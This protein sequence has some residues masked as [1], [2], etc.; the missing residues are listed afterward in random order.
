MRMCLG[1]KCKCDGACFD[2]VD[3]LLARL[4]VPLVDVADG[5]FDATDAEDTV[6]SNWW[7]IPDCTSIHASEHRNYLTP[8]YDN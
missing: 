8:T 2:G 5:V 3:A 4:H 6:N 7:A 1:K